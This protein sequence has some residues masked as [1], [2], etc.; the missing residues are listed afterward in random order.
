MSGEERIGPDPTAGEL[1]PERLMCQADTRDDCNDDSHWEPPPAS[2]PAVAASTGADMEA[3]AHV[4]HDWVGGCCVERFEAC[5]FDG[6]GAR[7]EAARLLAYPAMRDMLAAHDAATAERVRR[8]TAEGI[9]A[10][11]DGYLPSEA[12]SP[13]WIAGWH[14]ATRHHAARITREQAR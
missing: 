9:H 14:A 10:E 2:P 3:L 13:A 6:T 5:V 12:L 1:H 8:E 11:Y 4:L 7:E